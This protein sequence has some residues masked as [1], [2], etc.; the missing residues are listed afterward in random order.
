MKDFMKD[1][2]DQMINMQDG[3]RSQ[4]NKPLNKVDQ[5]GNPI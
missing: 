2:M 3:G 5:Y 1:Y 4:M